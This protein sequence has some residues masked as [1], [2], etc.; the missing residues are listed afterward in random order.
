MKMKALTLLVLFALPCSA[1]AGSLDIER[2]AAGLGAAG[3]VLPRGGVP[4]PVAVAMPTLHAAAVVEADTAHIELTPLLDRHLIRSDAFSDRVGHHLVAVTLDQN[5]PDG[6]WLS[7]TPPG[8]P[9][10][11]VLIEAGMNAR[12]SAGGRNYRVG[13][14][15]SI[16]RARLNNIIQISDADT[17]ELLWSRRI[18]E[19]MRNSYFAGEPVTVGG[20]PYRIFFAHMPDASQRPAFASATLGVCLIYDEVVG[21][22]HRKYLTFRVLLR[23]LQRPGGAELG[24]VNGDRVRLQASADGSS[25]DISR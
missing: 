5:G 14:D 7:V 24:L 16:F 4:A 9:A 3:F 10:R 18:I 21:G 12:W 6:A 17:G 20:R 11:M 22:V 15:I 1:S 23:A 13:M 2:L 8:L 19:V 25:L